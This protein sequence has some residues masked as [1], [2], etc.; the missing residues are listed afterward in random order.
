MEAWP[1]DSVQYM[2][3]ITDSALPV[4]L[5]NLMTTAD[6]SRLR[7][8]V[9]TQTKGDS[10]AGRCIKKQPLKTKINKCNTLFPRSTTECLNFEQ[11]GSLIPE[12]TE[13][14]LPAPTALSARLHANALGYSRGSC[15]AV[16]A[17]PRLRTCKLE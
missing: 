8:T 4:D 2:R 17:G 7:S 6:R 12:D 16:G 9:G 10:R 3:N 1:S 15:Y 13:A 5:V 14:S 11:I